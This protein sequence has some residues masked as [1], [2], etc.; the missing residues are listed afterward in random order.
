MEKGLHSFTVDDQLPDITKLENY[1]SFAL[2]RLGSRLGYQG[3]VIN[4]GNLKSLT[5]GQLL[6]FFIAL[7]IVNSNQTS[8]LKATK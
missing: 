2:V 8:T 5:L 7:S 1:L 6:F 4:M 3:K